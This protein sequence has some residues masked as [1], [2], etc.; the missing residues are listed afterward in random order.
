MGTVYMFLN[1]TTTAPDCG[2]WMISNDTQKVIVTT[3]PINFGGRD[4]WS[5]SETLLTPP[6]AA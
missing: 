2:E 4:G 5:G 1:V 3:K 6:A